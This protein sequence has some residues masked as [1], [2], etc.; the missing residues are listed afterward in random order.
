MRPLDIT[1]LA[2]TIDLSRRY[3]PVPCSSRESTSVLLRS[4]LNSDRATRSAGFPPF[5]PK[6]TVFGFVARPSNIRRLPGHRSDEIFIPICTPL[7]E[8]RLWNFIVS[9]RRRILARFGYSED[10]KRAEMSLSSPRQRSRQTGRRNLAGYVKIP[11]LGEQTDLK[12]A[13]P[14]FHPSSHAGLSI[15]AF[16][17]LRETRVCTRGR[18]PGSTIRAVQPRG[19]KI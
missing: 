12:L 7:V 1:Y 14:L 5:T 13:L 6:D 2:Q 10:G 9:S 11:P 18:C 15:P 16:H 8:R 4:D 3:H 19:A 17:R